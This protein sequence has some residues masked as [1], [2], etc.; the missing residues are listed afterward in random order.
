MTIGKKRSTQIEYSLLQV[1]SI[2]SI[3]LKNENGF[4]NAYKG[5]YQNNG[6]SYGQI[7]HSVDIYDSKI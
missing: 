7:N 2:W 5:E 4:H 6:V 3:C 1:Y